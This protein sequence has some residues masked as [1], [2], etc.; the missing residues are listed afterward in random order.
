MARASYAATYPGAPWGRSGLRNL[1]RQLKYGR[2]GRHLIGGFAVALVGSLVSDSGPRRV[3]P[4]PSGY[5]VDLA[6]VPPTG[7]ASVPG[8]CGVFIV[9]NP[10]QTSLPPRPGRPKLFSV[11]RYIAPTGPQDLQSFVEHQVRYKRVDAAGLPISGMV[12]FPGIPIVDSLNPGQTKPG[13]EGVGKVHIPWAILPRL[14]E[15]P[16]FPQWRVGGYAPPIAGAVPGTPTKGGGGGPTSWPSD[17]WTGEVGPRGGG[18]DRRGRVVP[19]A[20]RHIMDAPKKNEK[21]RKL[22]L[23]KGFRVFMRALG[24]LTEVNDLVNSLYGALP[25]HLKIRRKWSRENMWGPYVKPFAASGDRPGMTRR[26]N[27]KLEYLV[28]LSP[29]EK[30]RLVYKHFGDISLE[31]AVNNIVENQIEDYVFGRLG[32]L[33]KRANR[34][35]GHSYGRGPAI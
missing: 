23:P 33:Q 4:V 31:K 32:N 13:R 17:N 16:P 27:G 35:R 5:I 8:N 1:N 11:W 24:H 7:F 22:G 9:N 2:Y 20:G 6:C 26:R 14:A 3:L 15:H 28:P 19:S 12:S 21:E 25:V 18:G 10:W 34:K 30:A 29:V